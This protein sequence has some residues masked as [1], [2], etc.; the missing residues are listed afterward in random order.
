MRSQGT[1]LTEQEII[2]WMIQILMALDYLHHQSL[3]V[4]HRDIKP[5]NIKVT[6][7]GQV[8]L[9]D[10]G[11]SKG[12]STQTTVGSGQSSIYAYTLA[13]AP[14]E[15]IEGT[16]TDA[17]SDLFSLGATMYHLLTGKSLDEDPRCHALS[18]ANAAVNGQPD[19]L[20]PPPGVS[21]EVSKVLMQALSMRADQRPESAMAMVGSPVAAAPKAFLGDHWWERCCCAHTAGVAHLGSFSFS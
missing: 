19:P 18:R 13:Y 11:I 2:P 17:R 8:F 7:Q 15:Q 6:S 21:K 14:L 3:P 5:H 16:G 10:F 9:L 4:I 12:I 1:P 20:R